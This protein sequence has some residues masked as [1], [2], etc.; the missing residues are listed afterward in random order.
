MTLE[1]LLGNPIKMIQL[2]SISLLN[3]QLEAD[4]SWL[5]LQSFS[6]L[7]PYSGTLCNKQLI[8]ATSLFYRTVVHG[9]AGCTIAFSLTKQNLTLSL[10]VPH[11]AVQLPPDLCSGSVPSVEVYCVP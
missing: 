4:F 8:R 1:T 11:E 6:V 9:R 5:L 2:D 7:F 3:C 10:N